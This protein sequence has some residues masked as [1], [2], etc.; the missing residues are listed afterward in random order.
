VTAPPGDRRDWEGFY[1]DGRTAARQRARVQLMGTGLE[2]LTES[3]ARLWWPYAEIRQTQGSYAGEQVR[4]ER[5]GE[6]PEALLLPDAGVLGALH[7]VA[8]ESARRFH[9]PGR[10]R[11]RVPLVVG[12]GLAA[13]GVAAALYLWAI[14]LLASGLASQVPVSWEEQLG[15]TVVEQLAP[16]EKRCTEADALRQL[17]R[18]ARKLAAAV[19]E[20]PYTV[21]VFVV[22]RSAVNAFA[23][24]G[25]YIVVFRGLIDRAESPEE[26]AGVLAHELQ[27]IVRRHVTRSLF[28]HAST[29]LLLTAVT[30]DVTGVLAYGI[31]VAR[32]LGSLRYSRRSEE[33]ADAEGLR[34]L[35][36]AGIDP[37]GMIAFFESLRR[38]GRELPD[39]LAYLSTHPA[40]GERIARLRELAAAPGGRP[41]PVLTPDE[42]AALKTICRT[43]P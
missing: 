18:I 22:D 37:A 29:G 24:P 3:G 5:G 6:L 4:L 19:P 2:I 13:L 14:P 33:E 7:R 20:S 25:G 11:L 23:A 30:G 1:L 38:T 31:E 10:R 39:A 35:R 16:A 26:L 28:Q 8:P 9:D 43:R 12:A 41:A 15:K 27:H 34:T 42:W 36:A 40:T 32:T 21:R 17:D